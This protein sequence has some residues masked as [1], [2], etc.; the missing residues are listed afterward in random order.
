MYSIAIPFDSILGQFEEES[1]S[2]LNFAANT[3]GFGNES[4]E[5]S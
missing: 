2:L 4:L 5:S 1:G 3:E